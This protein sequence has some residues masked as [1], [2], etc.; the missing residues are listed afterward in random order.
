MPATTL[1]PPS[2]R[3]AGRGISRHHRGH[4]CRLACNRRYALPYVK[5]G[6][7]VVYRAADLE[8]F[9]ES[10]TVSPVTEAE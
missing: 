9:V 2:S 7:N 5:V 6:K 1:P 8:R 3:R 10:R 4:T